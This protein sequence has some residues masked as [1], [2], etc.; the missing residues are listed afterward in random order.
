MRFV[1]LIFLFA[2]NVSFADI[3]SMSAIDLYS[4]EERRIPIAIV[5]DNNPDFGILSNIK[6]IIGEDL[7]STARFVVNLKN[8]DYIPNQDSLSEELNIFRSSKNDNVVFLSIMPGNNANSYIIK[9]SLYDVF[10]EGIIIEKKYVISST[11]ARKVAHIIADV[12][13]LSLVGY[14]GDFNTKLIYIDEV[15]AGNIQKRRISVVDRDGYN[16]R[17]LTNS[18]MAMSPAYSTIRKEII[19][20]DFTDGIS[21]INTLN[22]VNGQIVDLGKI[23]QSLASYKL[24]SPSVSSDGNNLV[25]TIM[26][27]DSAN[28][29][30]L[31]F[32]TGQ[33][34]KITDGG[35]NVASCFSPDGTHIAYTS[36]VN[37]KPAIYIM[38]SNGWNNHRITF[39][40]GHY[41]EPEWSPNGE[42][43]A[44]TRLLN[45]VFSIGIIRPDGN[46]ERILY[47][48]YQADGPT[49]SPS[50]MQ[51]AFSFRDK[52]D[53]KTKI[54]IIDTKGHELRILDT[55]GKSSDITW[56]KI[57]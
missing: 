25:F 51:I 35:L 44:F 26:Q 7:N 56:V 8:V 2:S 9:A 23:Y 57:N 12:I 54:K 6:Q 42:W 24:I 17:Y 37:G 45:N 53:R 41:M 3:K 46:D 52:G 5:T 16:Q 13:M 21:R 22:V 34:N 4:R 11:G 38:S 48:G 39:E 31:N 50:S 49:W 20:S 15:G 30:N 40:K 19:Y 29:Y 27:N 28:I 33:F 18:G 1:L 55:P 14:E 43:I 47:S 32:L 36:N 10:S